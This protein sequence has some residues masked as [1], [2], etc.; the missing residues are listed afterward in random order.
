MN[1]KLKIYLET[2]I[3]NFLYAEDAPKEREITKQF[4]KTILAGDYDVF[5]SDAVITEI[6]RT[7]DIPRRQRLL[8]ALDGIVRLPVTAECEKLARGYLRQ[9][10]IPA[11]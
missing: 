9:G 2:T 6:N 4:F 11:K 3:P 1:Q 5:T 8:K 10:I 7:K